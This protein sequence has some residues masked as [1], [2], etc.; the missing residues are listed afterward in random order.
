MS[1]Y[2]VYGIGNALVDTE[3]EVENSFFEEHSVE[4]GLMTLVDDSRQEYLINLSL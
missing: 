4:K 2:D 1:K 3:F